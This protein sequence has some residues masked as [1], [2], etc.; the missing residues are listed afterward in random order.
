MIVIC[1]RLFFFK[2]HLNFAMDYTYDV[3]NLKDKLT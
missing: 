1:E 2:S 3:G